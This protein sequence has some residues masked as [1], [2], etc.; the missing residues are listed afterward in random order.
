MI[1]KFSNCYLFN[2]IFL[3]I[4]VPLTVILTMYIPVDEFDM[5]TSNVS[6]DKLPAATS[7]TLLHIKL[8]T[9]TVTFSVLGKFNLTLKFPLLGFG[10]TVTNLSALKSDTPTPIG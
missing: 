1:R 8:Y 2:T 4:T 9:S 10:Y 6:F 3:L 7:I 5:F